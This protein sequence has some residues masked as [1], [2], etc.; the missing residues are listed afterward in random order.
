MQR[1]VLL[2]IVMAA[3]PSAH[4]AERTMTENPRTITCSGDA[5]IR[6]TPDEVSIML[7]VE[8]FDKD[9]QKSK[10]ETDERIKRII[11]SAIKA[12][13]EE[14]RIATDQ[15]SIEP[16]YDSSSYSSGR[17]NDGFTV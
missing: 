14:K 17:K 1:T 11:S 3:A 2:W 6:V 12:G 16:H 8:A 13:V 9:L 10:G 15:M 7:G 5:E 4:A